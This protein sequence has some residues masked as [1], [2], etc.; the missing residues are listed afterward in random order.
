MVLFVEPVNCKYFWVDIDW[1]LKNDEEYKH[2]QSKG[3]VSFILELNWQGWGR[4]SW[5]RKE[6]KYVATWQWRHYYIVYWHLPLC[7]VTDGLRMSAGHI[8]TCRKQREKR[9]EGGLYQVYG[10]LQGR[11]LWG[12][13]LLFLCRKLWQKRETLDL[14]EMKTFPIGIQ[15][16]SKNS[17]L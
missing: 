1:K 16:L 6:E 5:D 3:L 14:W 10:L 9:S 15:Y 12:F 4:K 11:N 17:L 2:M 7:G 13:V 8:L